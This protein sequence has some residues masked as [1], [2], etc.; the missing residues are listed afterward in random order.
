MGS[1]ALKELQDFVSM[2]EDLL[3]K[4]QDPNDRR[5]STT[6]YRLLYWNVQ[7]RFHTINY[8]IRSRNWKISLQLSRKMLI[9]ICDMLALVDDNDIAQK[10]H[11]MID[12]L[13]AKVILLCRSSR[14]LLQVQ[15]C[16]LSFFSSY[17]CGYC[18]LE[19]VKPLLYITK[20]LVPYC[21]Q[22]PPLWRRIVIYSLSSL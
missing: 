10:G 11:N 16:G 15:D 3:G 5:R 21:L 20:K 19:Q 12:L 2:T 6:C 13:G 17:F 14:L 9:D 7:S 4:T 8:F 22:I 18:R 1:V